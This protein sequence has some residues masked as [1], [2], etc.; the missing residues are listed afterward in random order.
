MAPAGPWA[1]QCMYQGTAEHD[2]TSPT[3]IPECD[4]DFLDRPLR[5]RTSAYKE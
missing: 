5:A 4:L 1:G 2:A 3:L